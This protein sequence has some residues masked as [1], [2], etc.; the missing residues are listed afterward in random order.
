MRRMLF[1]R[2]DSAVAQREGWD[3]FQTDR[4]PSSEQDIVD[5]RP[6]GHRP[7]EIEYLAEPEEGHAQLKSD[8]QAWRIV[9]NRANAGS[10]PHCRALAFL[11]YES[12]EE[13]GAIMRQFGSGQTLK[14]VGMLMV[15]ISARKKRRA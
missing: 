15:N 12:P 13:F 4:D 9:V 3:V 1:R 14:A 7:Y 5:G 11:L 8:H 6:Y 10:E 2:T